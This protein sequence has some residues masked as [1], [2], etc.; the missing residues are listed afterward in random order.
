MVKGVSLKFSRVLP[1]ESHDD[2]DCGIRGNARA[3]YATR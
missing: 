1:R 2:P 3:N